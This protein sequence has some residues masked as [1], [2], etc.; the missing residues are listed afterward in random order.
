M[1]SMTVT[2]GTSMKRMAVMLGLALLAGQAAAQD[3]PRIPA[4]INAYAPVPDA[5]EAVLA[6]MLGE[7]KFE[8]VS[9]VDA[10]AGAP[11]ARY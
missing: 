6:R 4:C 2:K 9:P 7:A 3:A 10:F 1:F 8:G 11:D 5:Q